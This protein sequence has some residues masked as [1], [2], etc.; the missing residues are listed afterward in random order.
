MRSVPP[1]IQTYIVLTAAIPFGSGQ[2]A[3]TD[4][5]LRFLASESSKATLRSNGIDP[6]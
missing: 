5:L 6:D 2:R 3:A 1:E 4:E